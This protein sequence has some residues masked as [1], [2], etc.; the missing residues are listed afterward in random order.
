MKGEHADM[1][2]ASTIDADRLDII[3]LGTA[4]DRLMPA[5][6]SSLSSISIIGPST[7]CAR[8]LWSL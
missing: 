7:G 6:H 2:V 3:D 5:G 1:R 4:H 8:Q